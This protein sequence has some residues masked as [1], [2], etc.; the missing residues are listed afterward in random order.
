MERLKKK[1]YRYIRGEIFGYLIL[2]IFF[3]VNSIRTGSIQLTDILGYLVVLALY[4][5]FAVYRLRPMLKDL[6]DV[7]ENR[8]ERVTGEII[9]HKRVKSGKYSHTYYPIIRDDRTLERIK[10]IM[11]YKEAE[12]GRRYTILYLPHTKLATVEEEHFEE[13]VIE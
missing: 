2:L 13:Y 7:R 5:P 10:L 3:F 9:E 11:D 4:T 8:C 6:S 1:Y 12:V